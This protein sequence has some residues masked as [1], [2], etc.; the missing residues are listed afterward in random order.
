MKK[1][2]LLL[3]AIL[4]LSSPSVFAKDE[5]PGR[6]FND[7]PD[8][9]DDYQIH[10]IYMLDKEGQ[11]NEWDINGE[12][13]KE[14]L[15]LN[16]EMF[17]LTGKK[18]KYKF[19][20]REDGKLDISFVRLDKK[21]TNKGWNNSYPDY[22]IQK[23]GFNNPQKLYYSWVDFRHPDGGQ[24]GVH[25][26]YTFILSDYNI[27]KKEQR[28]RITLHE[29]LH[30]QGF[31]WACT[32]G[33]QGGHVDGPSI[34]SNNNWSYKL[35]NMIYEHDNTGCPDLK[36]S[37]YLTPTSDEPYDPLPM[38]CHLAE[39]AGRAHGGTY[40][41]ESQWPEKYN[42]NKFKQIEKRS[43]W[44]TYKLAEFAKD[45]WFRDWK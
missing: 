39:R 14:L 17:K 7:Q 13:E 19:D 22:F 23:L 6:F 37:V 27:G 32:N 12:M 16:E 30:G 42:H 15:E 29:L 35:G 24:M 26:G 9:S 25:S 41:F 10:F 2:L 21:G 28:I 31:A 33:K 40:G 36:D 44:C 8:V 43:Y 45:N 11:D 1:L 5:K 34:L 3:F 38:V 18:Q 20:Y 4:F